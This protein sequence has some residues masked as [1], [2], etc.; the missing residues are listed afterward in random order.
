MIVLSPP[1]IRKRACCGKTHHACHS[2]FKFGRSLIE[3]E[4]LAFDDPRT[5]VD[6]RM[7]GADIFAEN[8]HEKHL[9]RTKKEHADQNR[10]LTQRKTVPEN[11]LR[12]QISES[13]E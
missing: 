13:H 1:A 8:A 3:I 10:R 5:R 4:P 11:Q 9:D 2:I 12:D 6:L 7:N